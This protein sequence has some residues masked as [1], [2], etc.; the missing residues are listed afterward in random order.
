M[1]HSITRKTGMVQ[2][3][4]LTMLNKW[5]TIMTVV[6]PLLEFMGWEVLTITSILGYHRSNRERI[7]L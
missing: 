5:H 3:W 7:V 1:K 2:F 4:E 6:T